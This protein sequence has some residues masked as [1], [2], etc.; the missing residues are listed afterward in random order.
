MTRITGYFET[1][2]DFRNRH[3][4]FEKDC[5]GAEVRFSFRGQNYI[6]CFPNFD[7]DK[8][9]GFGRPTPTF[10]GTRVRL[11]WLRRKSGRCVFGSEHYRDPK[12]KLVLRFTCNQLI[13]QSRGC[14]AADKARKAKADL[15]LWRD[16]F[17][18]W[19]EVIGYDDLEGGSTRVEQADSIEC[20]FVYA[21]KSKRTR[22]VKSK[23]ENSISVI[24]D[25]STGLN[26]KQLKRILKHSSSGQ[27]P[28]GYY[29]LLID[30][31]KHFNQGKYR[32]S[33]LDSATAIEMTLTQLLDNKLTAS[34]PQ[35]RKLLFDKY[36]QI[37]GLTTAL[38]VLGETIPSDVGTKIG[39]PRN[40]A[41]HKGA[42]VTE[43][44]AREALQVARS[45][46]YM[47]LP[48]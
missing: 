33:M 24:A 9:D 41:I 25:I 26:I 18:K 11:D 8:P 36:R 6:I 46:I 37:S 42:E 13:V 35:Q 32:Q 16:V 15:L 29:V 30:A 45:F 38:K 20:Y 1:S 39:T 17:A 23:K 7:F 4:D 31:L 10:D 47:A 12:N 2:I 28:P 43:A 48:Y 34:T 5:V 22:R 44:Q 3:F 21:D 27:Y 19:W 14:V 40:Q